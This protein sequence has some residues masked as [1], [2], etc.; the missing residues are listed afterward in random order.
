MES[1]RWEKVSLNP[2]LC[3][4]MPVSSP[5]GLVRS[6]LHLLGVSPESYG[7]EGRGLSTRELIGWGPGEYRYSREVPHFLNALLARLPRSPHGSAG[8]QLSVRC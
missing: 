3:S 6:L 4:G 5:L 2:P 7:H 8:H 1:P